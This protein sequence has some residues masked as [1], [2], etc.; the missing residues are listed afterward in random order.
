M[1]CLEV[2]KNERKE[3]KRKWEG[4]ERKIGEKIYYYFF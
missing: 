4:N 2:K 1:V 3:M